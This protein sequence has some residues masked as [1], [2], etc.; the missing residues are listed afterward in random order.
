M[1]ALTE[2]LKFQQNIDNYTP[3]ITVDQYARRCA[4]LLLGH[5]MM[6]DTSRCSI[7]LVYLG[8]L[9]NI[10][11]AGKCSWGSAALVNLYRELCTTSKANISTIARALS[12]VI[13]NF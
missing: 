7:R 12:Q 13:V 8:F 11:R 4:L 9:E 3:E 5:L 2:H 10:T 1:A 6:F